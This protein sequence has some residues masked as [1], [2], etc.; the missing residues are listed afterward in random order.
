MKA[1]KL[2]AV[3][4]AL[5]LFLAACTEAAD[6]TTTTSGEAPE[7]TEAGG[8]ETTTSAAGEETTTTAGEE[9]PAGDGK[10]AEIQARGN[11][12]CGVNNAVPGFGFVDDAGEHV[13]F[14]IDFCR[15]IAAGVFG[16]G[17]QGSF[18]LAN[19]LH[20]PDGDAVL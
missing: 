2:L 1:S 8:E 12:L 19:D 7:T 4:T 17:A 3:L 11:L 13:G 10:L 5:M 9:A 18:D 15:A 16:D 20:G 6:T 14:D